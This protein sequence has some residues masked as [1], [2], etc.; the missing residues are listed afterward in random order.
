MRPRCVS[1]LEATGIAVLGVLHATTASSLPPA[2]SVWCRPPE[3][4]DARR[5]RSNG[6]P[7]QVKERVD[8]DGR[9]ADRA[10]GTRAERRAVGP[11]HCHLVE[12]STDAGV[13]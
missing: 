4:P 7:H 10:V 13:R 2:T 8:L 11:D 3:R 12:S 1:A 5:L 9:A 6:W